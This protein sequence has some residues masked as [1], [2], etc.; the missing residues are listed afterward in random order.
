M[1]KWLLAQAWEKINLAHAYR[2]LKELGRK[3]G[4]RFFWAA[5]IWEGIEDI[6]FP[7]LSWKMG[8][9]GLIPVFLVLHFE[10]IVYPAFFWGFRMWDR[11]QGKEPWDP[12]RPAH[13]AY[14]RSILKGMVFNLTALGW[15][16]H[17]V[18]WK[19]LL[20]YAILTAAFGFV[21]ERI[22]HDTNY[23]IL[24]TD[25][26][27][28]RRPFAKTGTY[29]LMSA[30]ILYP[31]LRATLTTS[32]LKPFILAQVINGVLFLI[33]ETVWAKSMWGITHTEE[34]Q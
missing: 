10:P 9:P 6:V 33:L 13:S 17:I 31:V 24:A 1:I 19:A 2:E 4:R 27:Q 12:N 5:L 28:Y 7:Y 34:H 29:L 22:W 32:I 20:P 16:S 11:S 30:F 18:P 3:H 26:V 14:W 23:G 21:H 8:V 15:L 25:S